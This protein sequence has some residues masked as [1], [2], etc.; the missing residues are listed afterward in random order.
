[1][2]YRMKVTSKRTKHTVTFGNGVFVREEKH[3]GV[4][5]YRQEA[6]ALRAVGDRARDYLEA[7]FKNLNA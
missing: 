2:A 1:M 4:A 5:W 6:Y 3:G 7:N